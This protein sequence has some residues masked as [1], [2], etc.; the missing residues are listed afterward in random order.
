MLTSIWND[1]GTL[2]KLRTAWSQMQSR[3]PDKNG[4]GITKLD[5]RCAMNLT[6]PAVKEYLNYFQ[7]EIKEAQA[8]KWS[9][10]TYGGVHLKTAAMAITIKQEIMSRA[11]AAKNSYL[12][13]LGDAEKAF[14][15]IQRNRIWTSITKQLHEINQA[16]VCSDVGTDEQYMKPTSG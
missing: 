7:S 6:D 15:K 3:W 2:S 12:V 16:P 9:P 5:N 14:D 8:G 13:F 10:T 1:V 4:K 11:R